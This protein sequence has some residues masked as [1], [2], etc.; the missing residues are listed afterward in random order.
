M[1][2]N[3][4]ESDNELSGNKSMYTTYF[5]PYSTKLGKWL[6]M[7]PI[8][9]PWQSPYNAFDGNPIFY[10][11]PSGADGEKGNKT[12]V[13]KHDSSN[14]PTDAKTETGVED[15]VFYIQAD[16]PAEV[17]TNQADNTK[18]SDQYLTNSSTGEIRPGPSAL[19]QL[20]IAGANFDQFE[21]QWRDFT[22]KDQGGWTFYGDGAQINGGTWVEDNAEVLNIQLFIDVIGLNRLNGYGVNSRTR[23]NF[24]EDYHRANTI[25]T[26]VSKGA[27]AIKVAS[28]E[29]TRTS[30]TTTMQQAHNGKE[31][32]LD[33]TLTGST[34]GWRDTLYS[35][36]STD[37]SRAKNIISNS[38]GGD[39]RIELKGGTLVK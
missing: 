29:D 38:R 14:D 13:Q 36:S 32:I 39:K 23:T 20:A 37:T 26:G 3:G 35:G 18:V 17:Q 2:F 12:N 11:D 9:H 16:A 19:D 15:G 34:V 6:L 27:N 31:I 28:S 10:A 22:K 30:A 24:V 25:A 7:D 8:V 5:R 33:Y 1:G 4:M 21:S